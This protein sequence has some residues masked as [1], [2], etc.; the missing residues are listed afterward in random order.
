MY[1]SLARLFIIMLRPQLECLQRVTCAG[2]VL[3]ARSAT[4]MTA[5]HAAA[6]GNQPACL[7]WLLK[8]G[9]TH[10]L[11]VRVRIFRMYRYPFTPVDFAEPLDLFR[12]SHCF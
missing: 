7:H 12:F 10:H 3:A 4:G 6:L 11:T 1:S 9:A 8:L 5:L 2:P